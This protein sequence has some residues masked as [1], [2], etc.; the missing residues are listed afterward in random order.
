MVSHGGF[1][2]EWVWIGGCGGCGLVD[3]VGVLVSRCVG[4]WM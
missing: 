3:V 4:D 1:V 2:G